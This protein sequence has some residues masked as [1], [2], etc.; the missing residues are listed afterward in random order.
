MSRSILIV[1]D[2]ARVRTSLAQALRDSASDVRVA[3]DGTR[4]LGAL[5][6]TPVDLIITDVRMP[7]MN[8]LEL[9]RLIK[10]R[11]PE[12]AV[13][14]MTAF[15]DLPTIATAMREGAEDFLVKPLDL[16]AL[17]SVVGRIF[18]DRRLRASAGGA[19]NG[20]DELREQ[21]IGH[22]PR[23]IQIFKIVGPGGGD[24]GQRH[25]PRGERHGQRAHRPG[26][27][28]RARRSPTSRSCPSTAR[29]CH[30]RCSN[31]SCSAT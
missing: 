24:A 31:P 19:P 27:S 18:E 15:D 17:R 11:A 29:R 22:D 23:M 5:A 16:H 25:H 7:E 1:D 6:E 26:P 14:L 12:T 13:V 28:M 20:G 8:G 21:L 9:L 4:A 2:D 3:E 10:E 30:R